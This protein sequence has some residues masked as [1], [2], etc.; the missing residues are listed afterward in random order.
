MSTEYDV[1]AEGEPLKSKK[2]DN[3]QNISLLMPSI[4]YVCLRIT[5]N[6]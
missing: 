1:P 4:Y 5:N 3:R 6:V 2:D